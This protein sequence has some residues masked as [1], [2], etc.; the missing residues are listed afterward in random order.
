[1]ISV[2]Q[3][4]YGYIYATFIQDLIYSNDCYAKIEFMCNRRKAFILNQKLELS[5]PTNANMQEIIFLIKEGRNGNLDIS[6]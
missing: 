3:G 4:I 2:M 5:I 1:M 6:K